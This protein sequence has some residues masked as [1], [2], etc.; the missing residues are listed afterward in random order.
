[1][2][3]ISNLVE[4]Y[5]EL[6]ENIGLLEDYENFY[7]MVSCGYLA[8]TE[9]PKPIRYPRHYYQRIYSNE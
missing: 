9:M 8:P 7:R 6:W 2:A 5:P 3:S 4:L 1:M